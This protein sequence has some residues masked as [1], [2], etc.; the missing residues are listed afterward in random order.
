M[1]VAVCGGQGIGP[2]V[3]DAAVAVLEQ[4]ADVETWR[5]E[6]GPDLHAEHGVVVREA[7]LDGI[8]ASDAV[9]FGAS[10][11]PPGDP[12]VVLTLRRA[13]GLHTNVRPLPPVGDVDLV[14][15]RELAEGLYVQDADCD[16]EAGRHVDRRVVTEAGVDRFL[17]TVAD[18]LGE[19]RSRVT[20]LHKANVVHGDTVWVERFTE[21]FPEG[22]TAIVDSGLYRLV[23]DPAAFD[24][25]VCPNLY[26]DVASDV[27]ACHVGSLGLLPSASH[28]DGPPL[29][30]PVHGTAPDIA[31]QG[32]ADPAGA[33]LSAAMLLEDADRPEAARVV[34]E[35]VRHAVR[36][37]PTPDLGGEASTDAF[38]EA[39]LDRL[40]VVA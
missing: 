5:F 26:G 6:A 30:E 23:V 15:Y 24:A 10:R 19:D 35:A 36:T 34:R 14:V 25:V 38:T 22:E 37:R 2:T 32:I 39:V 16:P 33:I 20:L 7:D 4:V 17:A 9:L 11:M 18:R 12:S 3:T 1:R 8:R 27:V 28:G 21:R 40:E 29:Y 31:G 13:L